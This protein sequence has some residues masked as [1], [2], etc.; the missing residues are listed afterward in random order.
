MPKTAVVISKLS[1]G[2]EASPT[3]S[4]NSSGFRTIHRTIAEVYP[5]VAV[6]PGLV[7]G[8]TDSRHFTEVADNSFR[9]APLVIRPSDS[10]RIHATNE[11]IKV[12]D[13]IKMIQY[14]TQL[15]RNFQP[16]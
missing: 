3:A 10:T 16:D 11:R 6:A 14:Y 5:D 12:S 15:I 4:A 2:R 1:A 9:F 7:L 8:G 13:Y